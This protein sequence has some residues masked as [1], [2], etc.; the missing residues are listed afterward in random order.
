ME[1]EWQKSW[2]GGRKGK[3]F[4]RIKEAAW[5]MIPEIKSSKQERLILKTIILT[6]LTPR[7]QMHTTPPWDSLVNYTTSCGSEAA[8]EGHK[9]K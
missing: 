7:T 3:L 2:N 6:L 5:E 9:I 8:V 1:K 4:N